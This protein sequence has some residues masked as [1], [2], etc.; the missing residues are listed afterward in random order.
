MSLINRS[1]FLSQAEPCRPARVQG[2]AGSDTRRTTYSASSAAAAAAAAAV[3]PGSLVVTDPDTEDV[4]SSLLS[5][6]TAAIRGP[7]AQSTVT[8]TQ[9]K[10]KT[11]TIRVYQ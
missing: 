7:A 9:V 3:P 2:G 10:S 1:L 8:K 6:R 4:I 11:L 5:L